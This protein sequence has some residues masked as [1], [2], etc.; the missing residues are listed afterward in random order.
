[1]VGSGGCAAVGYALGAVP[2]DPE[3]EPLANC[4]TVVMADSRLVNSVDDIERSSCRRVGNN[5]PAVPG[6][7]G[8]HEGRGAARADAATLTRS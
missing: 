7:P 2:D 3:A 8:Q 4:R 1:M 5:R 6:N